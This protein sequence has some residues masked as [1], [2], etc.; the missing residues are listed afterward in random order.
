MAW[1]CFLRAFQALEA[2]V[3]FSDELATEVLREVWVE[4][5]GE[6]GDE[7]V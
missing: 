1:W 3:G 5:A 2:L 6:A 4:L 7:P